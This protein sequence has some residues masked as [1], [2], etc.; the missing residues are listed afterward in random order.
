MTFIEK[1]PILQNESFLINKITDSVYSTMWLE[2]QIVPKNIILLLVMATIKE[3]ELKRSHQ[4][5]DERL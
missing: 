4:I 5:K 2:N 1:Y 3:W